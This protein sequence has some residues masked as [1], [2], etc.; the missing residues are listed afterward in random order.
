[1]RLAKDC[2]RVYIGAPSFRWRTPIPFAT[3]MVSLTLLAC[4]APLLVA[5][6]TATWHETSAF[7][8]EIDDETQLARGLFGRAGAN[9]GEADFNFLLPTENRTG[10]GYLVSGACGQ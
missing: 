4:I 5:R 10:D 6:A 1:M 8:L 3:A 9:A 2:C 7:R